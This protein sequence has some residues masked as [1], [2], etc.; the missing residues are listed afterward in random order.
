M[1]PNLL[2]IDLT[3]RFAGQIIKQSFP[4]QTNLSTTV[5]W[6]GQ[7][8]YGRP[9]QGSVPASISIGYVYQGI[10]Y[11]PTI[12]NVAL[13][14]FGYRGRSNRITGRDM[15]MP[16]TIWQ[17][18][19]V[20]LN[21]WDARPNTLAGWSLNIHHV[22][23]RAGRVLYR[24]DGQRQKYIQRI[25]NIITQV[26]PY[27]S[28]LFNTLTGNIAVDSAGNI[29]FSDPSR[30]WRLTPD[31]TIT[32]FAGGGSPADG[33]GDGGL[34]TEANLI[35]SG[36]G[37]AFDASGNLYIADTGHNRIR[38][39]GRSGVI[40][41]IAGNGV[42]SFSGDGG[43]ATQATL[44]GPRHVAVDGQGN[45]YIDDT[46]NYRVRKVS[47]DGFILTV[48]GGGTRGGDAAEGQQAT[49]ADL[50]GTRC[51]TLDV[52]GN[53]YICQGNVNYD[54]ER[55]WKITPD[56][57]LHNLAGIIH[58]SGMDTSFIEGISATEAYLKAVQ[59]VV[60][61]ARGNVFLIDIT[62]HQIRQ[63]TP[64]GW[65]YNVA[66]TGEQGVTANNTPAL[67]AQFS[68]GGPTGIA[69]D[70]EGRLL[71]AD[72]GAISLYKMS[73]NSPTASQLAGA[74]LTDLQ[75]ASEDGNEVYI[76]DEEG[77]HL[78]TVN[79]Q[80][81]AMLYDFG[82]D[83]NGRLV[84]VTDGDN[85]VTTVERNG[86]GDPTAIV[87]PY[88]QRTTLTTNGD[89]YLASIANPAGETHQFAYQDAGG[90]LTTFTNPRNLSWQITYDT[91]GRLTRDSDPAGGFKALARSENADDYQ[92][93]I[94]DAEGRTTTYA[95]ENLPSGDQRRID[96]AA[97]GTRTET[98]ID[99]DATQTLTW[100]DG[101]I[102]QETRHPDPRFGMQ[103]PLVDSVVTLPNGLSQ[104]ITRTQSIDLADPTN[105]LSLTRL[106]DTVRINGR[107]ATR[108][109]DAT[110]R[111][112]T[113]TSPAGRQINAVID[114]QGRPTQ[115]RVPGL[116]DLT[117]S[118]DSR[119]RPSSLTQGTGADARTLNRSYNGQGYLQTTTDALGRTVEYQYDSVGRVLQQT[120]P[121]TRQ[122]GY[123]YDANG[124]LTAL[125]PPGRPTHEFAY[126]PVNLTAEY[127]PPA[128]IGAGDPS[129]R[130]AYA[131]DRQVTQV[132]RPDGQ[133]LGFAYDSA[134]R[135]S[136]L[137]LPDGPMSYAYDATTGQLSRITTPDGDTLA[138]DYA[139]ALLTQATWTGA[140]TGSVQWTYD[141]DFR[142]ASLSVNNADPIA[143]QYDADSLLTQV[144]A[145][146][147]SRSP[148][149]GLLTGTTLGSVT[150][151]LS[152]NSFGEM[153][154]S[155][156]QNEST[157]LLAS[158]YT[159]DQLGRITRKVETVAGVTRTFEYGYDL[160][161][162]LSEVKQ[163][164]VVTA[165]YTYDSN[166]N[167]LSGP[168]LTTPPTYDDQDR[169]L[170]YGAA[171][172][173][174]TDNGELATQTVGSAVTQYTYDVL[175]NL[176]AVTL[177]SGTAIEYVVDGKNRRI[178][179]QVNGV[180]VQGFLYQDQLKPI[181]ELDG[182]GNLSVDLSTPRGLM[183]PIIWSR[184]A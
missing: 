124:N 38:K 143:F 4:P 90:L 170:S 173:T 37:L 71:I 184:A 151:S 62:A 164:N 169:L 153:A 15:R 174:Y 47:P 179:K 83:G 56:G 3:V 138:Y 146:T 94:T 50:R 123:G 162:R 40:T 144:G 10:Y 113:V 55:V 25:D 49:E 142:V 102:T 16:I 27:D 98:Q 111:T 21:T 86:A 183:C 130:S 160:A 141:N 66:G 181:A 67:Q 135:L 107:T 119:G 158:Q 131:L 148:Q 63:I 33:L 57:V 65:I 110:T 149:N 31:G 125:T 105:L 180:L 178:G 106:T 122:I 32:R 73:P 104:S 35:L 69:L 127:T 44:R 175:G 167:R 91:L 128:I 137:T 64:E 22:Y 171:N 133:T 166:G 20:P 139:G 1:H 82:Y 147:L 177:P 58:Q 117:V 26:L 13:R 80:T 156:A 61:D 89:G 79:T 115:V 145:L 99:T 163:D 154:S 100:A 5:T 161:G 81:G 46:G 17:D 7:D 95:V 109:F 152:Y 28:R 12:R 132:T 9:M 68:A 8:T 129:T 182:S 41:T 118:Y 24:G 19:V 70:P 2:R 101:T 43:P 51:L 52:R 39:V 18:Y 60:V 88:G 30:V 126:S 92:V 176:K 134:R 85:N 36:G 172:Y 77:R 54:I 53:L 87:G 11:T 14:S 140:V 121:D 157:T 103:A 150:S 29:Y 34:A 136:T 108:V 96:T 75:F 72:K 155:I 84:S 168:G 97:D 76:F 45:V 116:A 6:D 48:A 23:D 59:D 114:T 93:A 42:S 165:S 159:R 120:L 78:R 112:W 74:A